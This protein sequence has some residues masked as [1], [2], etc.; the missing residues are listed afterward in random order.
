MCWKLLM[1]E[2]WQ[3]TADAWWLYFCTKNLQVPRL[4]RFGGKKGR[5]SDP[6]QHLSCLR[7]SCDSRYL[8]ESGGSPVCID[9]LVSPLWKFGGT[10]TVCFAIHNHRI[11]LLE[12]KRITSTGSAVLKNDDTWLQV[13]LIVAP[14]K[15][16]NGTILVCC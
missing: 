13:K 6:K 15:N 10:A 9:G 2:H 16:F 11:V 14:S 1:A 4:E 7:I 8:T 12:R 5:E 3:L